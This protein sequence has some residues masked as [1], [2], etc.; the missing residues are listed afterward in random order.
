MLSCSR[1]LKSIARSPEQGKL[2][3][4]RLNSISRLTALNLKKDSN[5]TVKSFSPNLV[6]FYST[7]PRREQQNDSDLTNDTIFV[8]GYRA[9]FDYDHLRELF[10]QFGDVRQIDMPSASK[11]KDK[12]YQHAFIKFYDQES[13]T[14]AVRAKKLLSKS[15]HQLLIKGRSIP[16]TNRTYMVSNLPSDITVTRLFDH[17]SNH[18][19]VEKIDLSL[20]TGS[21]QSG[22]VVFRK[23]H[24]DIINI[25]HEIGGKILTLVKDDREMAR[26]SLCQTVFLEGNLDGISKKDL[27]AYFSEFG[28]I[29]DVYI[30]PEKDPQKAKSMARV[31][32]TNQK[33]AA[34]VDVKETHQVCG[35][36]L[37][38]RLL[39]YFYS[40]DIKKK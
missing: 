14:K 15:G 19:E 40:D 17:F 24:D 18:C 11:S 31:R 29:E 39:G 37:N 38:S 22:F 8:T 6:A 27:L 1:L 21:S 2:V 30:V 32:F 28:K 5:G 20:K 13:C 3:L 35:T 36:R 10:S 25:K 9:G 33:S 12:T 34:S 4:G 23:E 26:K 16:V 7:R